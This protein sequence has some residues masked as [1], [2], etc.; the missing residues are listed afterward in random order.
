VSDFCR[1]CP[2]IRTGSGSSSPYD[3]KKSKQ[4]IKCVNNF[5]KAEARLLKLFYGRSECNGWISWRIL[6]TSINLPKF[7]ILW[8]QTDCIRIR[9]DYKR[10]GSCLTCRVMIK[11]PDLV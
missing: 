6:N 11:D 9:N 5:K 10:S 7:W 1:I 3:I 4:T 2:F 8:C